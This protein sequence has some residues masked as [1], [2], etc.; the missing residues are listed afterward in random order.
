V[1]LQKSHLI[2]HFVVPLL[3]RRR[4][5]C[6]Y[7]VVPILQRRRLNCLYFVVPILQRPAPSLRGNISCPEEKVYRLTVN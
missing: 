7:F 1:G 6:L 3:Q 4:L 2:H 5:N